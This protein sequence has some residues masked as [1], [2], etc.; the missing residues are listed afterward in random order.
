MRRN[1]KKL[2]DALFRRPAGDRKVACRVWV[3][4]T[5]P[6]FNG[7][8]PKRGE[9]FSVYCNEIIPP[10]WDFLGV[11]EICAEC[12]RQEFQG[13]FSFVPSSHISDREDNFWAFEITK[14][15]K[16]EGYLKRSKAGVMLCQ[17]APARVMVIAEICNFSLL[18]PTTLGILSFH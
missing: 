1:V 17:A 16:Y 18:L 3:K 6:T 5:K 11:R 12:W 7:L 2:R 8:S 4:S 10:A 15:P 13:K 9:T 14:C